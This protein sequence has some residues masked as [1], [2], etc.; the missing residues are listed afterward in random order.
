MVGSTTSMARKPTRRR[1]PCASERRGE[2]E[3]RRTGRNELSPL[4]S[5]LS[6]LEDDGTQ[7]ITSRLWPHSLR[8]QMLHRKCRAW[9]KTAMGL[10]RVK[11]P[12][13]NLRV[14]IPSRFRK[15]ENQKCLRPPLR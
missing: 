6:Q 14:E 1:V 13:F 10:G 15:F 3:Q 12:T 2:N 4:H 9:R 8:V 7:S 5:I 11:T